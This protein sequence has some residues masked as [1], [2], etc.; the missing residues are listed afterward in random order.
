MVDSKSYEDW[1]KM[2]KKDLR[3]AR[4]LHEAKGVESK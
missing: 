3:G 1:I 4:I 2:A